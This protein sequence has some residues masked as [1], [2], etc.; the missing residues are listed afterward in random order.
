MNDIMNY[1]LM[2]NSLID[3]ILVVLVLAVGWLISAGIRKV[4][5]KKLEREEQSEELKL[6]MFYK[7]VERLTTPL[8]FLLAYYFALRFLSIDSS[9]YKYLNLI[10]IFLVTFLLIRLVISLFEYSMNKYSEHSDKS[11]ELRR[12][13]GLTSLIRFGAWLIG[14][15]FIFDNL[16]YEI[17]TIITGLGITG[18]AVALAAQSILGDLFSYFVIFFDRPFEVGEFI[19]VDDKMGTIEHIGIK[20][21]KI[22]GMSG[23]LLIVSNSNLTNSRVH[24][25][26][27][28]NKRRH[29]FTI[30]VTY[31]TTPDQLKKIP[32]I[33][34]TIISAKPETEVDRCH[35]KTFGAYSL[36]IET[37]LFVN[38]PDFKNLMNIVQEI[39]IEIIEAFDKEGI[40]F[41]YP[42]QTLFTI[43]ENNENRKID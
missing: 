2:G 8:I 10:Y 41:A 12:L 21:T 40:E 36:D 33:I 18:I 43:N 9:A 19:T 24:N 4:I 37:V 35:F 17:S 31:Q 23:E 28:L 22:R 27:K 38:N 42:T 25:F 32:E 7:V 26:K 1:D 16:G 11:H 6:A 5:G 30:G 13:R 39:N 34:T 14:L 29:V 15:L 3:Y 20:S